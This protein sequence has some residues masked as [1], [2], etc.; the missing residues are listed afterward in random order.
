MPLAKHEASKL[1]G[2]I[3]RFVFCDQQLRKANDT[4]LDI[5]DERVKRRALD[6]YHKAREKMNKYIRDLEATGSP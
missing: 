2:L 6:A 4:S 1:R 5:G 3:A